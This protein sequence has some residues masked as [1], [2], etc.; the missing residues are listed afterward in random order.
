MFLYHSLKIIKNV[1]KQYI[2]SIMA[3]PLKVHV[4]IKLRAV[5]METQELWLTMINFCSNF[6]TTRKRQVR[7]STKCFVFQ[8]IMEVIITSVGAL[9][10]SSLLILLQLI[11][12]FVVK[13][14]AVSTSSIA[15]MVFDL[16]FCQRWRY[17]SIVILSSLLRCFLLLLCC[18]FTLFV[19]LSS[20]FFF[21]SCCFFFKI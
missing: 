18:F 13:T 4:A 17:D 10:S 5:E 20:L 21:L 11:I 14:A 8:K 2:K 3:S 19:M 6:P 1:K 7:N 9:L 16:I 15:F 12:T